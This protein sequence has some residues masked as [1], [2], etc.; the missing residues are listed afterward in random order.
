MYRGR[1]RGGQLVAIKRLTKGGME[2]RIADFLTELGIMGHVN[3]PNTAKLIGYCVEDGVYLVLE[4]SPIGSL[5]SMLHSESI[6]GVTFSFYFNHL[7]EFGIYVVYLSVY[8]V[9]K[10]ILGRM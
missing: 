10:Q 4:L 7:C 3:H 9:T 5:A 1:L 2:E 6:T 8:F